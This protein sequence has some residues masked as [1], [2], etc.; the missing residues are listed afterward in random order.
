MFFRAG[1]KVRI[2]SAVFLFAALSAFSND[3]LSLFKKGQECQEEDDYFSAIENY[4]EA[5]TYNP[6]YG[7]AW[8]NLSL[9]TYYLGEYD[10]ALEYI[11]EALKYAKNYSEMLNL[12]GQIYV[13]GGN[14]DEARKIF[15]S[16][17]KDYPNSVDARFGL[18][19]L[20]LFEG[21]LTTAEKRYLDALKRD[22]RN[23]KALLSL[24]LVSAEMGKSDAAE[25]YINLALEYHSGETGVHYLASYLACKRGDFE[26]AERRARSA[27]QIDGNFDKAYEL[28]S[29]ILYTQG[30]F[31]EVVDLCDFRIGRNRNL[32]AAWYLKAKALSKLNRIDEAITAYNTGLTLNPQ[33]EIMRFAL[34]NLIATELDLEDPKREQWEKYHLEKA[35]DYA[36]NFDGM[37]ERYEYQKALSINP[38]DQEARQK[39]AD[40]LEKEGLYELYLHQLKFIKEN[41]YE[42]EEAE[43]SKQYTENSPVRQKSVQEQ[44]NDDII[45]SLENLMEDNLSAK[46]KVDPFYFDKSRWSIGIYYVNTT[47]QL[48]FFFFLFS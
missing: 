25:R 19:E 4:R 15:S 3:A 5:I 14:V 7:Q 13:A 1:I 30:R 11:N 10:L 28:L 24:A 32:S 40:M 23:R 42:K 35:A 6:Q 2:L 34:E 37:S 21:S 33:D 39:F 22:G 9:C 26:E 45:A 18:A 46:W 31:K 29:G 17:L 36:R 38:L 27:V 41:F 48:F 20:D 16:I 12:K 43:K 47:V 44:R 8:Y